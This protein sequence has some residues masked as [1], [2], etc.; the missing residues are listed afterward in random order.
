M[1]AGL[2]Q[3]QVTFPCSKGLPPHLW[4]RLTWQV[5]QGRAVGHCP[6]LSSSTS[7]HV[8]MYICT[9]HPCIRRPTFTCMDTHMHVCRL[10]CTHA[11]TTPHKH[12]PTLRYTQIQTCTPCLH[13]HVQTLLH[14]HA[15]AHRHIGTGA[16][17]YPHTCTHPRPHPHPHTLLRKNQKL[18]LN[19][20][21]SSYQ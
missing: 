4:A 3:L 2:L 18:K 8:G 14:P 10:T 13:I 21:V 12:T 1:K 15:H 20:E 5:A 9:P 11:H 6:P 16:Y 19:L 7:V 17:T